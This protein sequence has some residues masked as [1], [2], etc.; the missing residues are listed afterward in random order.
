[1]HM[2]FYMIYRSHYS[3]LCNRSHMFVCLADE[4]RKQKEEDLVCPKYFRETEGGKFFL[5]RFWKLWNNLPL[6]IRRKGTAYVNSFLHL[7]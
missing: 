5:V 7:V 2:I 4:S 6:D 3:K 1:M